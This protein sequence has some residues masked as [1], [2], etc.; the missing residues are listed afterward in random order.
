MEN[1]SAKGPWKGGLRC[2]GDNEGRAEEEQVM[3]A[4]I[5]CGGGR[6]REGHGEKNSCQGGKGA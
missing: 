5:S 4:A 6:K 1:Q 2:L 3:S